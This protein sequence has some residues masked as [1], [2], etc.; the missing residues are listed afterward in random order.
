MVGAS[1]LPSLSRISVVGLGY[2]GL[3]VA[4]VLASKGFK[5]I[6]V[7]T[8][9]EKV[10]EVSLGRC[11]VHEPGLDVLVRRSVRRHNL[12]ATTDYNAI[13]ETS[14]TFIT[15]GT[16]SSNDGGIDLSYIQSA[17]RSIGE[18]LSG[19]RERHLVVVKSTV[20]PGTTQRVI[21]PTL[22]SSSN[23]R[24]GE[25]L[26]VCV[27]PEFLREGSAVKD[28]LHPDRLVL[29]DAGDGSSNLLLNLYKVLYRKKMPP[30]LK[31]NYVNAELIKY[32]NN[33]FLATR[34]SL[35][36][37]F[38]NLCQLI[39]GA[40]VNVVAQG[41]GLDERIGPHFLRAGIGFGG[42]CFP[43][44][45]RAIITLSRELG[46]DP[47]LIRVTYEVNERR[48]GV[49]IKMAED[50]L[51]DLKGRRVAILGLAFKPNTDDVREAPA[52]K[53]VKL[54]A[55]KKAEVKAYDPV[56]GENAKRVLGNAVTIV[57]SIEECLRG[58]DLCVLA[59]EWDEFRALRPE[60]FIGFMREPVL[61]DGRRIYDP[62][63]FSSKMRFRAIGLGTNDG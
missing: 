58:A 9:E 37:E 31:T 62:K 32:A 11:P 61:I 17:S 27:N 18:S 53:L 36:N 51:G 2:V 5:V 33:V 4:A 21:V 59:T 50:L 39:P 22:E 23:H 63:E 35:I 26:F 55:E 49:V 54:F 41:I 10:S 1:R 8:D 30:V 19:K 46:H 20:V 48:P 44:D 16:P 38:A 52:L 7:D 3:T 47:E 60:H 6:G 42:S 13:R 15:V 40:D 45:L 14:V 29:G 43:K 25:S 56:A 34:I 12:S 28:M 24:V 57:D